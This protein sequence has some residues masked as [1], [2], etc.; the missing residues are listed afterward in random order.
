[1]YDGMLAMLAAVDAEKMQTEVLPKY[2]AFFTKTV[3]GQRPFAI[4]TSFVD[5]CPRKGLRWAPVNY[6]RYFAD[7]SNCSVVQ[8]SSKLFLNKIAFFNCELNGTTCTFKTK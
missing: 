3:L 6:F 8:C 5:S 4:E 2:P 7:L 1:M